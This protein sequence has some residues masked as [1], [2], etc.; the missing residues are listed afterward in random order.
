M[1]DYCGCLNPGVVRKDEFNGQYY[2]VNCGKLSGPEVPR[3]E[4]STSLKLETKDFEAQAT[5]AVGVL[6]SLRLAILDTQTKI[7]QF[8]I[9][10]SIAKQLQ[11]SLEANSRMKT[12]LQILINRQAH[13][14]Q[15]PPGFV[16]DLEKILNDQ[17]PS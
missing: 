14:M 7:N 4:I 12:K 2:C 13:S 11:T 10:Q 15:V 6:N 9:D 3:G 17:E 8:S 16:A 5:H 1:P